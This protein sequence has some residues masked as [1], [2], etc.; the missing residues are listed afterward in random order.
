VQVRD[1]WTISRFRLTLLY[2]AIFAAGVL[3]LVGLIYWQTAGYMG[4]QMD[5]VIRVEAGAL[6]NVSAE[7][8]PGR[9]R[10]EI[11]RDVRHINLFGLFSA[12]GVW[13]VGNVR[14]LPPD[15]KIDGAPHELRATDGYPFGAHALARRL[16]WGEILVVGRDATQLGEIRRIIL[17]ALLWSGA[18][19]VGLGLLLGAGLSLRP[20]Q[21]VTALRDASQKVM[22]GDLAA[23]L[24]A[25]P[26]GDELDLL[27]RVVNSML[28]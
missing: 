25:A 5:Q 28:D 17:H 11:D 13:I 1:L 19:I 24:P 2:G 20:L 27:A 10:E 18:L 21:H 15:L 3:L 7:T 26:A 4:R 22:R 23:R 6:V 9:V 8:L 16:P 12:D 14:T